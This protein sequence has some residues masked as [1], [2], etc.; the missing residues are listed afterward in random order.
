M[1]LGRNFEITETPRESLESPLAASDC[2]LAASD[3]LMHSIGSIRK[4]RLL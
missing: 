3:A 4:H 2:Y 1:L